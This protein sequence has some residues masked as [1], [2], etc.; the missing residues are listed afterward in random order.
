MK[1]KTKILFEGT[2]RKA[3]KN[4]LVWH[5]QQIKKRP[6]NSPGYFVEL[7]VAAQIEY[8]LKCRMWL[9]LK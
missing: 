2:G 4:M 3:L 6:K 1:P 7:G 9:P 8:L 5:K